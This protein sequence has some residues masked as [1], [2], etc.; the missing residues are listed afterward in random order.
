[1][2]CRGAANKNGRNWAWMDVL[3]G[4]ENQ[5]FE[6]LT[7]DWKSLRKRMQIGT[8]PN[9]LAYLHLNGKPSVG[10]WGGGEFFSPG[11]TDLM[12]RHWPTRK[13]LQENI[14]DNSRLTRDSIKSLIK[15]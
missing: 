14:S 5:D 12:D 4:I 7:E 2:H 3:S 15:P 9:D 1:M 8:D 6:L 10:F 11:W 13:Q